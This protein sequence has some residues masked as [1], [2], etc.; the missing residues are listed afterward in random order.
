MK[1]TSKTVVSKTPLKPHNIILWNFVVNEGHNVYIC[2]STRNFDSIFFLGITPFLNLKTTKIKDTTEQFVSATPPKPLNRFSWKFVVMKDIMH[3]YRKCRFDLFKEQ[4]I[5][6][7]TLA[8]IFCA[9]QM[10]LVLSDCS[11][12]MFGIAIRCIQHSQAMLERG[13]CELAHSFFH[14]FILLGI[15]CIPSE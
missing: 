3:C 12:L 14:S 9:T 2:K 11:S 10:K 4:I 8:K 13:L 15:N 5:S 1:D 7:W 6:L